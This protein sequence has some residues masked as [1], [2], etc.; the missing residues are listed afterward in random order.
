MKPD[1]NKF[2]EKVSPEPNTGCWLWT[3]KTTDRGYGEL[4]YKRKMLR[5]HRFSYSI[6]VGTIPVGM[7]V[8]HKCDTPTCVNPYH[9][10]LGTNQDNIDDKMAKGRH[11]HRYFY[12]GVLTIEQKIHIKELLK[13][14]SS[15]DL[16]KIY[17]VSS[18]T[19]RRIRSWSIDLKK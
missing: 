4:M 7:S 13:T 15:Y 18:A 1:K 19:I 8:C 11:K 16:A 12:N 9:L 3:G 10:F 2:L 17:N 6:F 14:R 5:A